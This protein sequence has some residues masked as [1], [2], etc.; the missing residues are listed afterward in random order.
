MIDE[1]HDI[2]YEEVKDEFHTVLR[3][4][5]P[6]EFYD[7]PEDELPKFVGTVSIRS[8]PVIDKFFKPGKKVGYP[9]ESYKFIMLD[10]SENDGTPN[11]KSK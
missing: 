9:L 2:E 8:N 4:Y 6:E 1:G 7:I 11:I 5:D 10:M 3:P